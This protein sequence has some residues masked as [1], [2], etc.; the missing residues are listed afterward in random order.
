MT[1][2][3]NVK[4]ICEELQ[5]T[6]SK[7]E[8]ESILAKYKDNQNFKAVLNFVFNPFV[9]SGLSDKKINKKVD[10]VV[11]KQFNSILEVMLY[12]KEN[13]TGTDEVIANVQYFLN[14]HDEPLKEFYIEILTKTLKLG[15]NA[16]TI[17]KVYGDN[18][19]PKFDVMLG[20]P[21]D[22]C[23][24][25]NGVWFS[26]SHKLNGSRCLYY[27]GDFYTRQGRK[28]TGLDHIKKDFDVITHHPEIYLS[29]DIVFDGELIR[30]NVNG[31]SDS[32]NFQIG[33]GI[34]NSKADIKEELKLVIF[35]MITVE[36]FERGKSQSTYKERKSSIK[37]LKEIVDQLDLKNIDVVETVYEG[38]DQSQIW[39]WLDYAEQN[40]WEG[41]MLN[42][43]T[44]YVCKRTKNLIKVKMFKECDIKCTGIE[45]G[46][47]RNKNTLGAIICDYKGNECRVGSGFS[48]EQRNYYYNNPI[49][50]VGKIVTVKYKEETKNKNGGLS[51]QFPIYICTPFDKSDE[52]YN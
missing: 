45:N 4:S 26:V 39:K 7:I 29:K 47:G 23:K 33:V 25:P 2:F 8:K 41:V 43:D 19:I 18:F 32:E 24:I 9:L 1:D 22:K 35:D 17:N 36:D 40:D 3:Y 34:A 46:T 16:T 20:T 31:L 10:C 48:D 27:K 42:L 51:I 49:E 37:M 13:N 5:S 21:I 12:L 15:C 44:S 28:Y 30:K 50:I 14:N 38:T 52:S 11:T 6:N